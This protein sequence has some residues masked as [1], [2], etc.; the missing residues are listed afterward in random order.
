MSLATLIAYFSNQDEARQALRRLALQ[1]YRR[2]ALVHKEL[3]G[4]VLNRAPFLWRRALRM[5]L[6]A[7]LC[8]GGTAIAQ[9]LYH[10]P[11]P[12][13]S[14]GLAA[15]LALGA[16][17]A[18]AAQLWLRRSRYVVDPQALR[19]HAR[20]LLP[21]ETVLVLQA[22]VETL[23]LPMALLRDE[24]DPPPA[25]FI[26]H[27]R[28]ER[29]AQSRLPGIKLSP[30]QIQE[31]AERHAREQQVDRSPGRG[32]E[33]LK[34]LRQSRHWVRQACADLSSASCLEQKGT[35]AADW[36]LDNEYLLEGNVRD[37]LLNLPRSFYRQLPILSSD[38]YQGQPCIYGLAKDLVSHSEL[39]LNRES[40]LAFIEAYQSV[41]TLSIGELWAIPQMLRIALIES[42]QNLAVTALADLR[43]R[44]LADFWANRLL[45][46]NR[47][48]ANQL[49]GILAELASAEPCPTPYFAAQNPPT[50]RA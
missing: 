2:T 13:S 48:D 5:A 23:P 14:P 17:G 34:R 31:H 36:I 39:R 8:G 30:A 19:D 42:I 22:P 49:F 44:Q 3:N 20:R 7:S 33:L 40:L 35:P 10:W 6:V 45:A 4:A 37:V 1:G 11:Q 38:P 12:L 27:P 41:R 32:A 18:L 46:A 26:M 24:S 21:G 47:R 16:A 43:E 28:R 25:L 29:R 50:D 9:R 15:S